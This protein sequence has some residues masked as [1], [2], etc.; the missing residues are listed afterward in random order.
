[1]GGK[2]KPLK[3]QCTTCILP[4]AFRPAY[5]YYS[6]NSRACENRPTSLFLASSATLTLPQLSA[7]GQSSDSL[8]NSLGNGVWYGTIESRY[9]RQ[10]HKMLIPQYTPPRLKPLFRFFT[11]REQGIASRLTDTPT[12]LKNI[13][14]F[15]QQRERTPPS[16]E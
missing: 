13:H 11:I 8:V 2:G 6:W 4:G 5:L 10:H 12:A 16:S 1:M 15:C 7:G 9:G 3:S 14:V